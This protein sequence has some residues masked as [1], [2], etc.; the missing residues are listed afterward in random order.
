L[1]VPQGVATHLLS[2]Q[3][4]M[5][6]RDLRNI[7]QLSS[8]LRGLYYHIKQELCVTVLCQRGN[9]LGI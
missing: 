6:F 2:N 5:N 8:F 1:A 3:A 7:E 4:V 9:K